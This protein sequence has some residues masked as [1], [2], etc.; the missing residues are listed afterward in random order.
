MSPDPPITLVS[1]FAAMDGA[2]RLSD[3]TMRATTVTLPNAYATLVLKA[4]ARTVR[5]ENRDAEDLWRCLEIAA[6]D[7]VTPDFVPTD[8]PDRL[9]DTLHRELGPGGPALDIL[10]S[11]F[12]RDAAA[13]LRTRIRAL[14]HD[15]VGAQ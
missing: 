1:L 2:L 15:V 10:T 5:S 14:L 13:R 9:R 11:A 8:D 7:G 12:Q 6:A 3:G 4:R